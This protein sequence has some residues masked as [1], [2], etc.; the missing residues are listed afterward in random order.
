MY[1]RFVTF[2]VLAEVPA[3]GPAVFRVVW[4]ASPG[5]PAKVPA[6]QGRVLRVWFAARQLRC[7]LALKLRSGVSSLALTSGGLLLSPSLE[8]AS[9]T[10]SVGPGRPCSCGCAPVRSCSASAGCYRGGVEERVRGDRL[11]LSPLQ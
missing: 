5:L 6:L 2:G 4:G 9:L 7:Y 1:M 11:A 10:S 8:P 3:V